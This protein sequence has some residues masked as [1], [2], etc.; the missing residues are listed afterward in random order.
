LILFKILK[1]FGL[2]VPAKIEALKT[3]LALRAE[4]ASERARVI[5]QEAAVI[6]AFGAVASFAAALAFIVG[7]FALYRW[8]AENY[9]PYVGLGVVGGLLV[10]MTAVFAAV[11]A[12]RSKSMAKLMAPR[13]ALAVRAAATHA[14]AEKAAYVASARDEALR[15]SVES[16]SV[17][18]PSALHPAYRTQEPPVSASDLIEPLA[19][20]LGRYL[21]FPALANPIAEELVSNL[22]TV[23][24]G[25]TEETIGRAAGVIRH[26]DRA[27]MLVVLSGAALVGW[28]L[29]RHSQ[30][31]GH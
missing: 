26:G 20:F 3:A 7:L 27:N 18:S 28:L 4:E 21:K 16:P 6:A 9:G 23:A 17:A 29:A 5:A 11:A 22:R 8:A 19:F 2:D 15:A 24:S 30:H 12:S 25:A 1:L 10:L 13:P 14:A 31:A